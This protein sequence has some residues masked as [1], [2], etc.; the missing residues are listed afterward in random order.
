VSTQLALNVAATGFDAM[1]RPSGKI[2]LPDADDAPAS[3]PQHAGN[4]AIPDFVGGQ[5]FLPKRAIV[6]GHVGMLSAAMP[7]TAV[8]EHGHAFLAKNEI[9][10]HP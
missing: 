4:E 9:H 6:H 2:M 5:V 10:R 7:E 3:L 1:F 8:N